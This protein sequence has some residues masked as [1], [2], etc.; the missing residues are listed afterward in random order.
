MKKYEGQ[1]KRPRAYRPRSPFAIVEGA[2]SPPFEHLSPTAVWVL[3]KIY[4]KFN[5]FNRNNL[6]VTYNEASE[7]IS[8]RVFTRC[9]WELRAFGFIEVVRPGRLERTCTIFALSDR[10]RQYNQPD[11]A[12]T[13]DRLSRISEI[14]QEIENLKRE[15]WPEGQKS[16]KRQRMNALRKSL[17]EV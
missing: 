9:L 7:V 1:N 14:L 15:K 16:E 8:E 4:S 6:S 17:L 2:G 10:W 13:Q 11:N 12:A 5:G 3:L